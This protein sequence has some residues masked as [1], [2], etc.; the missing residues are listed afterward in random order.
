M[1][2]YLFAIIAFLIGVTSFFILKIFKLKKR[3]KFYTAVLNLRIRKLLEFLKLR[4][5]K[6][7]GKKDDYYFREYLEQG[8]FRSFTSYLQEW[9]SGTCMKNTQ[10]LLSLIKK[11][12]NIDSEKHKYALN[13]LRKAILSYPPEYFA[14]DYVHDVSQ[15]AQAAHEF[16]LDVFMLACAERRN[17]TKF[18]EKFINTVNETATKEK[19]RR[20]R[21]E[22]NATRYRYNKDDSQENRAA[23]PFLTIIR[24][25]A[26][27]KLN[28]DFYPAGY[29]IYE[30][31]LK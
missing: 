11:E 3:E 21:R 31:K 13:L 12:L 16:I 20:K 9:P 27:P 14:Y 2:K 23:I 1:E 25:D 17:G 30:E 15:E 10:F 18:A 19:D 6:L 26:L 29:I 28:G 22:E 4:D 24:Y 7:F 8:I 5:K